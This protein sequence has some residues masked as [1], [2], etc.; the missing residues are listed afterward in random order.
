VATECLH[1]LKPRRA[2]PAIEGVVPPQTPALGDA[3]FEI[4]VPERGEKPGQ[5]RRLCYE[6]R[7]RAHRLVDPRPR[8]RKT[9]RMAEEIERKFLVDADLVPADLTGGVPIRQG[10]LAQEGNV[11]ARVRIT[12]VE[13]TLTVKAGKGL[14]RTEVEAVISPENA[15]A[16]WVHTNG[17]RI[18]KR[19][20]RVT[21][22]ANV[23][24]VDLYAGDITGLCTAEVEFA[25]EESATTFVPPDWF[26]TELTG[27]SA[28]SNAS[29]AR[30]GRPALPRHP[31]G[32]S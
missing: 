2:Q 23:A 27:Q 31:S 7:R 9:P 18:D 14:S 13:A 28:W 25:D 15:E 12:P 1:Q 17:R 10:Y 3:N 5:I 19:R 24:E 26:G 16:L 4:G 32:N 20:T 6:R 30:K 29:L 21:L 22:G 11:E 8:V